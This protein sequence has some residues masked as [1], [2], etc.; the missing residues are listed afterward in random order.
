MAAV[1]LGLGSN[2][3]PE[4]NLRLAARELRRHFGDVG[5]S[6]VYR[7]AAVGFDG[8]DFL[9][10]VARV[11]TELPPEEI[12]GLLERIHTLAGRQRGS[13]DLASR[14]LDIDLLL[15]DD[16]VIDTPGLQLPRRDVLEYGFVLGPLA[17]LAPDR[18]HPL[19]G[20]RFADHWREF[21]HSRHPLTRQDLVL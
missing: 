1:F 5:L 7:S 10:L 17:E 19:T 8:D 21:D 15:Y 3:E 6:A 12:A 20:R 18:R 14:T 13:A 9:N 4:R 16:L 2:I 11:E